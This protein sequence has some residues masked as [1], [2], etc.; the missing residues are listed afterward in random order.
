MTNNM[1]ENHETLK[2]IANIVLEESLLLFYIPIEICLF[3]FPFQ[4]DYLE[5]LTHAYLRNGILQNQAEQGRMML[6]GMKID[7][8][9][10]KI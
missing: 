9:L 10:E 3:C 4:T 2:F 5:A 7:Y 1:Y 8:A 6:F